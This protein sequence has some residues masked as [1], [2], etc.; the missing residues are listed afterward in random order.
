MSS[1]VDCHGFLR[2]ND[3]QCGYGNDVFCLKLPFWPE[4]RDHA[5]NLDSLGTIRL[6]T[7]EF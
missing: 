7:K 3:Y 6:L 1:I 5:L 4:L 2:Y